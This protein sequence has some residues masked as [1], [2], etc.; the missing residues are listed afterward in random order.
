MAKPVA[1]LVCCPDQEGGRPADENL[2]IRTHLHGNGGMSD[3]PLT[4]YKVCVEALLRTVQALSIV[5]RHTS[6]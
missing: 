5:L 3:V 4:M 1:A 6:S 2:A